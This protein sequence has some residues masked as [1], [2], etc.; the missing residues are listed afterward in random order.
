VNDLPTATNDSYSVAANSQNQ[1]L[2]VLSNDSILPDVGETLT[3]ASVGA[4]S[5]GGTVTISGQQLLY[6]PA[7]GFSGTETFNYTISDGTPN[8]NA[9]ATV[10]VTV[11]PP[12]PAN[13]INFNDY[14]I[15]S[16][17]P[18]QDI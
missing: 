4:T 16:Y 18:G 10:T 9:T 11:T 2:N 6:T 17:A 14:S 5:N 8:S 15:D 7:A 12:A 3:I 13:T 1:A